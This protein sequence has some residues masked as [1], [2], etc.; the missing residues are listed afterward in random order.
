MITDQKKLPMGSRLWV[1]TSD[2]KIQQALEILGVHYT[3]RNCI[4]KIIIEPCTP[5]QRD[6]E[7][8]TDT[9]EFDVFENT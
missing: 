2:L 4:V 1:D 5:K 9:A 6:E 8:A 7:Q 3:Y